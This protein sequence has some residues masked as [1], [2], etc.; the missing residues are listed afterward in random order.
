MEI[1]IISAYFL[2][3]FSKPT[4]AREKKFVTKASL[5]NIFAVV[6]HLNRKCPFFRFNYR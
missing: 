1:D 5:Y 3:D 2:A 4:T 6:A